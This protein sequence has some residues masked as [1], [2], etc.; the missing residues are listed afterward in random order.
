MDLR[1]EKIQ[2]ASQQG[3]NETS[4]SSIS[5]ISLPITD[6]TIPS[7]FICGRNSGSLSFY[8]IELERFCNHSSLRFDSAINDVNLSSDGL[9]AL[10]S[11]EDSSLKILDISTM[12]IVENLELNADGACTSASYSPQ[13]NII[14]AGTYEGSIHCFDARIPRALVRRLSPAHGCPVSSV[15][16][17]PD[18]SVFLSTGMDGLARVWDVLGP[19]LATLI[20]SSERGLGSGIFSPNGR[21]ALLGALDDGNLGLWD[22]AH[23]ARLKRVRRYKR[24]NLKYWMKAGFTETGYIV[25]GSEDGNFLAWNSAD[26]L[27]LSEVDTKESGINIPLACSTSKNLVAVGGIGSHSPLLYKLES[28]K[29]GKYSAFGD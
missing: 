18:G 23:S 14:V 5:S 22:L 1:F 27:V 28:S 10:V 2:E 7:Y 24:S 11:L 16:F 13:A 6:Q 26:S 4:N 9:R 3:L 20:G 29:L 8:K 12:R 19:C 25:S 15:S 17:H 21:Y